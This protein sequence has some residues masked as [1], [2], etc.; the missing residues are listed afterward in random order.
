M[1]FVSMVVL[2]C[3][4]PLAADNQAP[5]DPGPAPIVNVNSRY[6]VE[7]I[8][9]VGSQGKSL[10]RGVQQE[11]RRLVGTNLDDDALRRLAGKLRLEL[12]A[13]SVE[14][15]ILR[16]QRQDHVK[17]VYEITPKPV[18]F[19]VSVPRF[20]YHSRQGWTAE[21]QAALRIGG[22]TMMFGV[23][24]DND[25]LPERNSGIKASYERQRLFS[26][27]TALVVEFLSVRQQWNGAS[28]AAFAAIPPEEPGSYRTRQNV[29]PALRIGLAPGL[30]LST[31]AS[32]QW[33]EPQFS[34]AQDA[35]SRAVVNTLR[36][37]R[38]WEGADEIQQDLDAGYS[39]RAA[40]KALGS[41]LAYTRH[42]WDLSYALKSGRQG[43]LVSFSAG[44]LTGGAPM[45]ER[46]VLGNS[47]SLR[48]WN[49]FDIDPLGGTRMVHN[50]VEYQ[51]GLLQVFYDTGAVWSRELVR[52]VRHSAGIGLRKDG[53]AVALA[54][55][56][57]EGRIEP[58][59]LAGMNF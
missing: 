37:H 44:R 24:S 52:K 18:E 32:F 17:V 40:T 53:F 22:N 23:L 49:R 9:V 31:G 33:F 42:S 25:Q 4:G 7:S 57:R 26:T 54:F 50:S 34:A 41:D 59:V 27:N 43:V 45:F 47:T 8:E 12:H 36:Y 5:L 6:S 51:Y 38:Q 35:T 46:Y 10:S 1:R 13:R 48:G 14:H 55:P 3:V 19:D 11:I 56:L 21:A 30:T 16:G 58:I 20:L 28:G 29:E 15:R 2:C 39:L